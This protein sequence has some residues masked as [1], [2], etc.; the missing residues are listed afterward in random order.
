V[1]HNIFAWFAPLTRT[2]AVCFV[3]AE[4]IFFTVCFIKVTKTSRIKP[5]EELQLQM[6]QNLLAFGKF[7]IHG[8]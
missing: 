1:S 2:M 6:V 5:F 3:C 4:D 7:H 8:W